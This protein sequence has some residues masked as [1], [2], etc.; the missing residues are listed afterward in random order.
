MVAEQPLLL[1]PSLIHAG[2]VGNGIAI[3]AIAHRRGLL[4]VH[5][6]DTFD[7]LYLGCML[8]W[9]SRYAERRKR[10]HIFHRS[11]AAATLYELPVTFL[12]A[13]EPRKAWLL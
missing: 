2:I 9:S 3:D 6:E 12:A 13:A 10:R 7:Q 8:H 4:I 5:I 1:E 11:C